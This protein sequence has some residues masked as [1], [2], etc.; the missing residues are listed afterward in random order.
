MSIGG[1][2][3]GFT[4]AIIIGL[5]IRYQNTWNTINEHYDQIVMAK[6]HYARTVY[7]GK[8]DN[9]SPHCPVITA[10]MLEKFPE[11]RS[12]TLVHEVQDNY[13]SK[14]AGSNL[15]QTDLGFYADSI[16]PDVFTLHFVSTPE[17]GLLSSPNTIL[18]SESLARKI[19][20]TVDVTGHSV[21]MNK[22]TNLRISGVYEDLPANT[23]FRPEYII[24]FSTLLN[25]LGIARN[26]IW[27]IGCLVFARLHSGTDISTLN[28]KVR[29]VLS[30]HDALKHE[31]ITLLPLSQ[32]QRYYMSDYYVIVWIFTLVGIF[33]LCMSVFNY[34]NLSIVR[35]ASR[36][37]EVA[38]KKM[39]GGQRK[40]LIGQFL[41]ESFL[42]AFMAMML[43]V[44]FATVI[45]PFFN[46]IMEVDLPLNFYLEPGIIALL[47]ALT[48]GAGIL[49]GLH[50]AFFIT[51]KNIPTLVKANLLAGT[52]HKINL[53]KMLI[54]AQFTITSF[55][56]CLTVFFFIQ[57]RD[58]KN[59][60]VGFNRHRLLYAELN[61]TGDPVNFE[62][63][64]AR[65][66]RNPEIVNAAMS[67]YL[68]FVSFGGG[69]T[70][71]EGAAPDEQVMYRPNNVSF[72]YVDNME[73]EVVKGRDFSR[74]YPSDAGKACII[75][76]TAQ[77]VFGW[78]DPIGKR[79]NNGQWK[80]VGVVKD[81]HLMDVHNII[82]PAILVLSLNNIEGEKVLSFRYKPGTSEKARAIISDE[83]NRQFPD[84]PFEVTLHEN[85]F[86]SETAFRAYMSFYR[87]LVFFFLF[88]LLLV[89]V[90]LWALVTFTTRKR[91]KEIGIRKINGCS[92]SG[93]FY[94]LNKEYL[95]IVVWAILIALPPVLMVYSRFPGAY[96]LPFYPWIVFIAVVIISVI[97]LLV[98]GFV[99]FQAATRNPVETLRDE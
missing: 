17:P 81:Y 85:A 87:A 89:I 23:T 24:S 5:F 19:F 92:V 13:F 14:S 72:D 26:D 70:N 46:N 21:V 82:E 58:I 80:V 97:T 74:E 49:A 11:F 32:L 25:R 3:L 96:K 55:L 65:L 66:L 61:N 86:R 93:I 44:V 2:A 1:L 78:D 88:T 52:G 28:P 39:S 69:M 35:A 99:T 91:T 27:T 36:T 45:L 6:R 18:L 22:K 34:I 50:P 37:K 20:G 40:S 15:F 95:L 4:A 90:G 54:T 77:R 48:V 53:R 56:L 84:T 51:S 73:I 47:L 42:L 33:I 63:L 7:T 59:K 75:N 31:E 76:E 8:E 94:L 67:D 83:L 29:D 41:S 57:V 16:Y 60:D 9:S 98:T 62:D 10:A 12:I 79:I 43:A 38:V 71:W 68:P 64:R 30:S